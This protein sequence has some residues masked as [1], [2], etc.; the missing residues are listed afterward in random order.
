MK[1]ICL[2]IYD[3][4]DI[5]KER[6]HLRAIADIDLK[7]YAVYDT[8]YTAEDKVQTQNKNCFWFPSFQVKAGQNVVIYTRAGNQNT[9]PR[10]DGTVFHFFFRGL[11]LPIYKPVENCAV[12]FEMANWITSKKGA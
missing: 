12:I 6:V 1:V 8:V 5:S 9:E 3:R 7:F 11:V 4:G 2:G 10:N